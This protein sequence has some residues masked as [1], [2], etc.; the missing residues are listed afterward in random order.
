MIHDMPKDGFD[1]RENMLTPAERTSSMDGKSPNTS[2]PLVRWANEIVRCAMTAMSITH[3]AR[4][5]SDHDHAIWELV[6][7]IE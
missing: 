5:T 6:H 1:P 4:P 3:S 7:R 2:T